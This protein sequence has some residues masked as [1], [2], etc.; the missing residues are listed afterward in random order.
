M[1]LADDGQQTLLYTGDFKLSP[2][3]TA[4]TPECPRA[5]ILV[6]ESTFGNPKYRLPPREKVISELVSIVRQSLSVGVTPVVQA[7]V[8]GK[9][10]E[11]TKILTSHGIPVL[12]HR[13]IF[14]INKIY[15]ACGCEMGNVREYDAK[16]V[17]GH[18]LIMPPP[19]QS[20]RYYRSRKGLNDRRHGLGERFT[21]QISAWRRLCSP[22]F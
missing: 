17:E 11:V 12:Q 4:E 2:S 10:Q 18:A 3:A 7:Y 19:G 1:L 16:L 21:R 20:S 22:S 6:M 9:A 5:E 14:A 15:E 13:E 8:L